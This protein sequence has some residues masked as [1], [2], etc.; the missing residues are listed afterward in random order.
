MFKKMK[1]PVSSLTHL[2]GAVIAIPCCVIIVREAWLHAS[3]L[4]AVSFIIFGVSL[5][6]LYC[7]SAVY[8][9]LPLSEK[10]SETLRRVDHMMIFILIAGTYTPI[11]LIPLHGAW[12]Y[13]LLA[14]VWAFALFGI[15]LKAVWI[16]AP[17]KLSTA[18]YLIMG[19]LALIAFFP[20]VRSLPIGGVLLLIAGGLTYSAGAV[21]YALK[22]PKINFKYFGFHELFH[23]FVLGG[24]AFHI[25]LMFKYIL[26]F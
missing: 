6:L 16:D 10:A 13:T 24:S 1:D 19:W 23:L 12:G 2:A 21:I 25:V 14:L 4:H 3:L 5:F 18:L 8:H 22:R 11:C 9:M 20:L 7:A 17:R 15:I 26:V